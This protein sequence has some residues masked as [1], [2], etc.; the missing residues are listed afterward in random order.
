MDNIA[1]SFARVLLL[2]YMKI[3]LL[4]VVKKLFSRLNLFKKKPTFE[5]QRDAGGNSHGHY[6]FGSNCCIGCKV[7]R[8]LNAEG[9]WCEGCKN[10][11]K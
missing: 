9:M 3:P 8:P 10:Y 7:S 5:K 2:W 4:Q 6:Q 1:F 11:K